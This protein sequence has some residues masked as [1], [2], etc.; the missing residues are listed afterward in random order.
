MK[1]N[2]KRPGK[3][4]FS[5]AIYKFYGVIESLARHFDVSRKTIHNWITYY[6]MK[7]DIAEARARVDDKCYIAIIDRI[8]SGDWKA[9]TFWLSVVRGYT[10][11]EE[12][13]ADQAIKPDTVSTYVRNIIDDE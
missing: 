2:G 8:E 10:K 4:V 13:K 1:R 12:L 7:A 6:D 11:E 3:K 9:I 5:D